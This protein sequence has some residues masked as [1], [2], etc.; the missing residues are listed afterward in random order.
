[1]SLYESP[2]IIHIAD[3]NV[4]ALSGL[5]SNPTECNNSGSGT[6]GKACSGHGLTTSGGNCN[7]SGKTT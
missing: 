6:K 2:I 4:G 1:M 5:G 7:G 3:L